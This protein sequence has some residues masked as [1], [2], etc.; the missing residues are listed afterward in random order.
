MTLQINIHQTLM[1]VSK[2]TFYLMW[3]FT[4]FWSTG[5]IFYK[6]FYNSSIHS[7][8]LLF[9][10]KNKKFQ[11]SQSRPQ[12]N[13][14]KYFL[15]LF[16]LPLRAKRLAG[17]EVARFLYNFSYFS[18]LEWWS[19]KWDFNIHA[20]PDPTEISWSWPWVMLRT[21]V[22]RPVSIIR[23]LVM[24]NWSKTLFLC[25]NLY[26]GNNFQW[27]G[28]HQVYRK[29]SCTGSSWLTLYDLLNILKPF[30]TNEL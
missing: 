25:S 13:F 9:W 3:I 30:T 10:Y 14:K 29:F 20:D 23:Q 4:I 27:N 12:S 28:N 5:W 26:S 21:M 7:Y 2:H 16:H 17:D 19:F 18:H 1:T 22:V 15:P 8:T 11:C 6:C 24:R